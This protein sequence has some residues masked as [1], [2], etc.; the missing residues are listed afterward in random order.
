MI[1][2]FLLIIVGIQLYILIIMAALCQRRSF[3]VRNVKTCCDLYFI[4]LADKM[5]MV[6]NS[7]LIFLINCH[8]DI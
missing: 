6:Q 5:C 1:N 8:A 2:N 3:Q 4:T 7:H